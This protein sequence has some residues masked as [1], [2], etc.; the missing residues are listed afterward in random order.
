MT[1]A[2][3]LLRPGMGA[4]VVM[5]AARWQLALGSPVVS[6]AFAGFGLSLSSG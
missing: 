5:L 4:A 1:T 2:E 3:V 6:S